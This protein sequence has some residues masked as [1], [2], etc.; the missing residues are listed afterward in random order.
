MKLKEDFQLQAMK[1]AQTAM[2]EHGAPTKRLLDTLAARGGVETVQ[3]LCKRHR[4]S[5]GFDFCAIRT[6][7]N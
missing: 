3:E 2:L 5:D 7:E 1:Q 6:L 4:A